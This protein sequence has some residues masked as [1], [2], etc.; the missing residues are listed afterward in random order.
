[1]DFAEIKKENITELIGTGPMDTVGLVIAGIAPQLQ[2]EME[3]SAQYAAIGI[4]SSRTGAAGQITAVDEAVKA[5]HA[6]VL[7]I[8]LPRDTKG[9]G[10]HGCYIVIGAQSVSDVRRAVE[11]ALELIRKFAGEVIINEAGHLEFAYSARAGAALEMAFGVE[12]GR[13][14]GFMAGS[15]AGIG[16]VMADRAVKAFPVDILRYM[17]PD[18]GTSHTNEVIIAVTGE[19]SAVRDAVLL[20]KKIGL[21]LLETMGSIPTGFGEPYLIV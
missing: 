11:I 7:S 17:T 18:R 4:I 5:T 1:M 2:K 20:G 21:E 9:W 15:P 3:T 14:F 10:G 19:T 13:P 12:Q 8:E 16:L 6:K